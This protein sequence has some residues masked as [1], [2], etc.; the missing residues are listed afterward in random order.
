MN[1]KRALNEVLE[2]LIVILPIVPILFI[3]VIIVTGFGWLLFFKGE[4]APEWFIILWV[5]AIGV[6]LAGFLIFGIVKGIIA[7]KEEIEYGREE[8]KNKR[9]CRK[10]G[11]DWDGCKCHRC[12]QKRDEGHDWDECLCR[13]CG[14]IRD[15]GHDWDGCKCRRC[16]RVRSE[17]HD[18]NGCKCRRCGRIREEGHDWVTVACPRCGGSG[19]L[20]YVDCGLSYGDP[21]YGNPDP[22][23][24]PCGC[25]RQKWLQCSICGQEKEL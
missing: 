2:I 10:L 13:R 14:Q 6:V 3:G 24:P 5:S 18:W 25:D 16:G 15:V 12:R 22:Q 1:T 7:I 17:G 8:R 11:H 4:G 21:D 23:G 20:P 9:K 19:Y